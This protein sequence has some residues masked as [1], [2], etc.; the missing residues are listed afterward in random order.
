V[1]SVH[2]LDAEIYG[3]LLK[4]AKDSLENEE[5]REGVL[6]RPV[7]VKEEMP[8]ENDYIPTVSVCDNCTFLFLAYP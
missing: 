7:T 8:P 4:E 1:F 2:W 3:S 5:L 6:S